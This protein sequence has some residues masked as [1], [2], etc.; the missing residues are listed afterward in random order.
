[1]IN[2]FYCVLNYVFRIA[3]ENITIMTYDPYVFL[4]HI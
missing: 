3:L 1:M 4:G 2:F